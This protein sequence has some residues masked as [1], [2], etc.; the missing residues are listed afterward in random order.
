MERTIHSANKYELSIAKVGE[1]L[2]ASISL[3]DKNNWTSLEIG[4]I[5]E[6]E[7]F[8]TA[9]NE[10]LEFMKKYKENEEA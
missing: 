1:E 6:L 2:I 10:D 8:I 5:E 4:G 9:I 3:F 7:S